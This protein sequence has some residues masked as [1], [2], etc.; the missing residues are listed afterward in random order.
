MKITST[1]HDINLVELERVDSFDA[2]Y[3]MAKIILPMLLQIKFVK[4]SIP[5]T[6]TKSIVGL[7]GSQLCF[8]FVYEDHSQ[9]FE[10]SLMDKWH[11]I[12]D[13]MIWS[14]QQIIHH[15]RADTCHDRFEECLQEGLTLFA[16]YY[17][18]LWD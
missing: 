15:S 8:D 17:Q 16:E 12:L 9:L 6:L 2:D 4:D 14:F 11:E 5:N 3:D 18:D 7:P 1:N 10:G 13:K